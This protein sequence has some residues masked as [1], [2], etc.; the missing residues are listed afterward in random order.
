[1]IEQPSESLPRKNRERNE[2]PP[3]DYLRECFEYDPETGILTWKRRPIEHFRT[4]QMED[5]QREVCW[6]ARGGDL[7]SKIWSA[8]PEDRFDSLQRERN[9]LYGAPGHL[10]HAPWNCYERS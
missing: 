9:F 3:Q 1:M 8:S 4:E 7:C 2:L 10:P 6:D 5:V